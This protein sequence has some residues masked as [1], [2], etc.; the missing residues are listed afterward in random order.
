[1]EKR[2]AAGGVVVRREGGGFRVLLIRDSYG[3]WIWP[4]GHAEEGET[5]PETAIREV[6]EETGIVELKILGE[7]GK[8]EYTYQFDA[9][10]VFKIVY[11]YLM[12]TTQEALVI[13]TSEIEKGQWFSPEE[14][15]ETIEYAGSRQILENALNKYKAEK[16]G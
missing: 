1:M 12:E 14:A 15:I 13:Q 4:K 16:N 6:Q 7:V 8:Q 5:A 2:V 10:E 11:I 9:K 3:H